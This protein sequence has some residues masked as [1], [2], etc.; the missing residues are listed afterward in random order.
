[1]ARN[2]LD[3]IGRVLER[4]ADPDAKDN[5]GW[6]PLH[7]AARNGHDRIVQLLLQAGADFGAKDKS[8]RTALQLAV[9]KDL[10]VVIKLLMGHG[11]SCYEI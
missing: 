9:E 4:G 5:S 6:T 1:M 2:G 11:T 3:S 8:G 10:A 7:G